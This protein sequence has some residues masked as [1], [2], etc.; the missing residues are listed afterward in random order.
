MPLFERIMVVLSALVL[1]ALPILGLT[2]PLYEN[3]KEL[4]LCIV[5]LFAAI[6]YCVFVYFEIFKIYICLDIINQ[7][8]II[9]E[10]PGIKK[11]EISIIYVND[12]KVSDGKEYK[13]LFALDINCK[14]FTKKISSWSTYPTRRLAMFNV[15]NRQTRR[16]I[17]FAERCNEYLKNISI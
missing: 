12:L 16:L 11:E 6:L 2:L 3:K 14:G 7:K 10:Y 4:M 17:K 15:Y 8:L 5:I 13:D 1:T 9:R